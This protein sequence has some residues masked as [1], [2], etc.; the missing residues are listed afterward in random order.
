MSRLV[1]PLLLLSAAGPA[2]S[3]TQDGTWSLHQAAVSWCQFLDPSMAG[4]TACASAEADKCAPGVTCDGPDGACH[5]HSNAVLTGW[6]RAACAAQIAPPPPP[7]TPGCADGHG[8]TGHCDHYGGHQHSC[9][10]DCGW[11]AG[12]S[13]GGCICPEPPLPP[14]PVTPP[15]VTPPPPIEPPPD[16]PPPPDEPHSPGHQWRFY[17]EDHD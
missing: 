13:H 14:P 4:R 7:V 15:P 11:S 17:Y 3:H 9:S 6:D 12:H 1:I 2:A 10:V 16:Q 5:T 8:G